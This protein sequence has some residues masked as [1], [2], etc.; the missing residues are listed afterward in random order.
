MLVSDPTVPDTEKLAWLVLGH[1]LEGSSRGEL[2]LLPVAAAALLS[3]NGRSPTQG[4]AQTFG[5]DEIGLSRNTAPATSSSATG[6]TLAEQRVLTVGKRISS[7]LYLTYEAGLD[8][9]TRVVRVQYEMS[10]R[11]SVRAETGTRSALDLFYTLRFD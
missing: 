7:K 4:I 5:L 1:G 11:W 10:R 9:A 6:S 8:A 2:D 3:S